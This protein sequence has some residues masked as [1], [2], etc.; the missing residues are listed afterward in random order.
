MKEPK[1]QKKGWTVDVW[2]D[3]NI[4]GITPAGEAGMQLEQCSDAIQESLADLMNKLK[5]DLTPEEF[6]A[7]LSKVVLS[8]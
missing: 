6:I 2:V 4:R 3:I 1:E 8:G 7:M 5:V